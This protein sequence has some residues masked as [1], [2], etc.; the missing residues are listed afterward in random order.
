M[1]V[2]AYQ[3]VNQNICLLYLGLALL[4][5]DY[6]AFPGAMLFLSFKLLLSSPNTMI[7][8]ILGLEAAVCRYNIGTVMVC[9]V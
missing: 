8:K 4:C 7:K 5:V 9:I 3:L 6:P 1:C 2:S